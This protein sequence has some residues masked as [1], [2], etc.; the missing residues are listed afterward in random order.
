MALPE[1]DYSKLGTL[2]T[3]K[4]YQ[5]LNH[6]SYFINLA[7]TGCLLTL[8]AFTPLGTWLRGTV[9]PISNPFLQL[10]IYF[11]YFSL[12]FLVVDI[13][14]SYYSGFVIERRF[15]LSNHTLGSWVGDLL[16]KSALS[17]L[18]A[19]LLIQVFYFCMRVQVENWWWIT[20]LV[21]LGFSLLFSKILPLWII[22]LFYKYG[23]IDNQSLKDRIDKIANRFGLKIQNFF[24]LN[25]SRTTKKANAMF[26]GLGKSKRVVLADTLL[27]KFTD[28]EIEV[29]VAHEI[30]H[31]H[32]K[33]I[34]K[35]IIIL[36]VPAA[37]DTFNSV[38]KSPV[39]A[40]LIALQFPNR[41]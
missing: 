10:Q 23:P 22:P 30:G 35:G 2:E 20:W 32:H 25:L 34:L 12:I 9:S 13:P 15:N 14:M 29:V 33:H 31:C 37:I 19:S 7:L 39:E 38:K 17:F 1:K 3:A 27:E 6:Q 4:R 40:S 24:S 16:K 21:Y 28:D 18:I 36:L 26:A 11:I 5:R 8:L 41:T